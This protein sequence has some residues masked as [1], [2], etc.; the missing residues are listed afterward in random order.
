MALQFILG[1]SRSGKTAYIY[2]QMIQESINNPEQEFFFLVPDQSTL[3]AQRELVTRHPAHGTMNID[4]VGFYR[5][6]YRVFEE[7]SYVPKE[8]LE[9][10][11]K[12]MVI[13]KVMEK[14]K[15]EL[16]IFAS[17]MKKQGFIEELKS[18]FAEMYQYDISKEEME[19]VIGEMNQ[20]GLQA[21]MKEI[22]LVMD[23]FE[24]YIGERY[25]ISEQ[26]LDVFA[27]KIIQ[28]EKLKNAVIYMD[29]F[30][31]FTPIQRKVI[32]QLF[33]I[34]KDIHI[35]MTLGHES[36][37]TP[38][39]EYELFAMTKKEK[40]NLTEIALETGVEVRKDIILKPD[41]RGS[42]ELRF[43]ERNL[44]R[45]PYKPYE[46]KTKDI[47]LRR[48]FHPRME[49]KA[50]ASQIE[51]LVR[52]EGYQYKD[53]VVLTADLE[54]YQ[55]E[56]ERSL[57]DLK[58]PY[59]I[60]ANRKLKNN[61]CIETVLSALKMIQMDFSYDMVFRY[62]KSGF[63]CLSMEEVDLLENYVIATGIR[64]YARWSR[65]FQSGA[66]KKDKLEKMEQCRAAFMEE[67]TLLKEGMKK[68][69]STVLEKLTCLYEFLVRL[70]I[71]DKMQEKQA[72]FEA[73]GDLTEAGTYG[74]VYGQIMDLL[75][76]MADILGEE[77]LSYDDFLSVLES[78]L[79]E[80]TM[81]VIPP[82]LDQVVVGDMERTRTEGV[83]VLFF[84]GIN[85]GIIPNL[86]EGGGVI[87]DHQ[88]E[89]LNDHGI[90]MAP[91]TK[92]S[93]YTEQFYLYLAV[94]KPEDKLFLSYSLMT[95]TGESRQP[96]YF[97]DRIQK[98]FPQLTVLEQ[99]DIQK[100]WAYT[101]EDATEQLIALMR[102]N[103]EEKFQWLQ[104]L[105]GAL[106]EIVPVATYLNA[107]F[108]SNEES[109]ISQ[110]LI[111]KLYGDTISGSVT[112]ME[113]FAGCAFSHFMQYGLKLRE[114]LVHEIL[115]MDMG[116]VFH[117]TMELVGK[118]TDW[119]FED[120]QTR[121]H[122][123]EE[124]VEE[125]VNNVQQ[126]I[127]GSTKRNEYLMV[128]MKRIAKRSVWAMEQYIRR[129]E[130]LPE[131]YEIAFSSEDQL[132][133]MQFQ[134]EDGSRMEFSGVVDRMDS[135]EDEENKYIKIID[136][137]SGNMKFDFAKIFHG[138]QMQL[139]IYMNAMMELQEKRS[140]KRVLPA[141]MFYYHLD[142]PMIEDCQNGDLEIDLLRA[143]KMSGVA[144]EDFQ[145][146][147]KMEGA[148]EEGFLS[149]PVTATK[150]GYGKRSS[151]LNTNQML[152]LGKM[153]EHKMQELG[154]SLVH[155]EV[156]IR[157]YE[158]QQM[159]PCTY[160][161]FRSVCAYEP[162]T[163]ETR[164]IDKITLEEGKHVLDQGT[165]ESD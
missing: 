11:G 6:A 15:K 33:R 94:T 90:S 76:Q 2:E 133:S 56:L 73:Q 163:N 117:K 18:F 81:G 1:S 37:H 12:S 129:G 107:K 141:G 125:A 47:M 60:D 130:F 69:G 66:F 142:D 70:D 121:D 123:V 106:E 84:V 128:R 161:S 80:M 72:M 148:G 126:E 156:S 144:N 137:K 61:P 115:P 29:G 38:Y 64:G 57:Q 98:L 101:I 17:S 140:G 118:N 59:F 152:K 36:V 35:S 95:A 91:T 58:I 85:D 8:L 68:R 145:L 5:L 146:V 14:N 49:S 86:S 151:I 30:T 153:V 50:V 51:T 138:L 135:F 53:I 111:H 104:T 164:K 54:G 93:A 160:C 162:G 31:G 150:S 149:L 105:Y 116:Q 119:K 108:Y 27:Q 147:D 79:E 34:G 19:K 44:F 89:V 143:M 21:K 52:K 42:D 3:N 71:S 20:P 23:K 13:R 83:K 154:N 113:Q 9:D 112:R 24:E 78:G 41:N 39:R 65:P 46:K 157:P 127:L 120:D 45:Y 10:E 40:E 7:L 103:R 28:S 165:T 110:A 16:K 25:L 131:E 62:L 158:Y 132:S 155:G 26:L 100:Q 88:R 48:S 92:T 136:Y 102:D 67:I 96:S 97:L 109:P 87:S 74:R 134:M 159:T 77:A 114:R 122:F 55:A 75:D 32:R 139:I 124:M 4:V 22:L 63:S 82:S 43:L 99:E